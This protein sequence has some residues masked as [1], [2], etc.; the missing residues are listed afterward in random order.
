MKPAQFGMLLLIVVA[1]VAGL[2]VKSQRYGAEAA[3]SGSEP[4]ADLASF[5]A[6]YGWQ[7]VPGSGVVYPFRYRTFGKDGCERPLVVA[8][9][10]SDLELADDA[11]LA[12]GPDVAMV[13]LGRDTVGGWFASHD[14]LAISPAPPSDTVNCSGPSLAAWSAQSH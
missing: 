7:P 8:T 1:V 6:S 14:V 5:L 13:D 3:G 4:Q 12:L 9:L 2:I 10:G 11:Q